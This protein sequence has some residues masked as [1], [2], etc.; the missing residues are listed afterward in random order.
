MTEPST[1]WGDVEVHVTGKGTEIRPVG[2]ISDP[3]HHLIAVWDG[4]P[5]GGR[6]GTNDIVERRRA[7]GQPVTIIWP[8][9]TVRS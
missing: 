6:G 2:F 9:G 3:A 7:N 1:T 8:H 4:K 5:S